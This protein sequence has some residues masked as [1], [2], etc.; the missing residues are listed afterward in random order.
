[1]SYADNY[2]GNRSDDP[3]IDYMLD[4]LQDRGHQE[5]ILDAAVAEWHDRAGEDDFWNEVLGP[6]IDALEAHLG[7]ASEIVSVT[8]RNP[9]CDI[10]DKAQQPGDYWNGVTGNHVECETL[11]EATCA[12]CGARLYK[13]FRAHHHSEDG[14]D[15]T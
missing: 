4:S 2:S 9:V 7:L 11:M 15:V 6:A 5:H 13:L 12:S 14:K 1:M 8:G 3:L 10:C